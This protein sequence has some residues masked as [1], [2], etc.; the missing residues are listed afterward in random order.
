MA[1]DREEVS[2]LINDLNKNTEPLVTQLE[3]NVNYPRNPFTN[4]IYN[5]PDTKYFPFHG[6]DDCRWLS[7]DDI[8]A[9]NLSLK[10]E[11]KN[12]PFVCDISTTQGMRYSVELYNVEQLDQASFNKLPKYEKLTQSWEKDPKLENF[13]KNQGVKIVHN[14]TTC[15]F[16]LSS[17]HM[18]CMP[19]ESQYPTSGSY[20]N[21]LFHELTHA[22]ISELKA[23][24]QDKKTEV[25][26]NKEELIAERT[27]MKLCDQFD[28]KIDKRENLGYL[29]YYWN[30]LGKEPQHIEKAVSEANKIVSYTLNKHQQ[31]E[32]KN[33][34]SNSNDAFTK[35]RE[36]AMQKIGNNPS[37]L[38][39]K[40]INQKIGK[41]R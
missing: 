7:K 11:E 41:E 2:Q 20:Y 38:N 1:S 28:I 9:N 3:T 17:K 4:E 37:L 34:I 32:R 18:I 10:S 26:Y 40:S 33:V 21:A 14:S 31:Q 29:N 25:A 39:Q 30:L 36:S 19:H 23:T 8:T 15:P 35:A 12:N 13:I 24:P 27:A 16:Y 5:S 6:F 22:S